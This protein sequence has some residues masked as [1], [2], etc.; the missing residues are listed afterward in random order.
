[1]CLATAGFVEG[2]L[3]SRI[4]V[5]NRTFAEVRNKDNNC[6]YRIAVSLRAYKIKKWMLGRINYGN[7]EEEIKESPLGEYAI[8]SE[9]ANKSKA[10]ETTIDA[11]AEAEAEAD[12]HLEDE[13]GGLSEDEIEEIIEGD[14]VSDTEEE[15]EREEG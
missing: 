3:R 13:I 11:E 14:E 4:D 10:P 7:T 8:E 15:S 2:P 6:G 1:M 12:Q 5:T 9:I